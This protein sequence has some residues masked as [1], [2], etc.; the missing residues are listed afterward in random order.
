MLSYYE[1]TGGDYATPP[2]PP[3]KQ[4]RPSSGGG[5]LRL[6]VPQDAATPTAVLTKNNPNQQIKREHSIGTYMLS[7]MNYC[8]KDILIENS[9]SHKYIM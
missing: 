5:G 2:S 8:S 3:W 7:S 4:K 1:I 9:A 6:P